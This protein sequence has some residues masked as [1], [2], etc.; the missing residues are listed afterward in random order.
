MIIKNIKMDR[1][2]IF[3]VYDKTTKCGSYTGY[4][5]HEDDAR[6]ELVNQMNFVKEQDGVQDLVLKNDRVVKVNDRVEEIF[7]IIHP[8]ML[9]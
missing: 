5:K 8:I 2:V 1:Q 6:K 9:R 4:F 7:Y 3:G